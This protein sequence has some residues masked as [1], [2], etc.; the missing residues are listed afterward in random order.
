MKIMVLDSVEVN[1]FD[2]GGLIQDVMIKK[3]E[4]Y[5]VQIYVFDVEIIDI[6]RVKFV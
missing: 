3:G 4:D 2:F 5:Y 1:S 6:V